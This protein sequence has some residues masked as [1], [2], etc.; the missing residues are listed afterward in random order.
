[1]PPRK[2]TNSSAPDAHACPSRRVMRSSSGSAGPL[3]F[4]LILM[5]LTSSSVQHFVKT[6]RLTGRGEG[7]NPGNVPPARTLLAQL[8]E[9]LGLTGK[10]EDCGEGD[11]GACTVAVGQIKDSTLRFRGIK[12]C[13]RCRKIFRATRAAAPAIGRFRTLHSTWPACRQSSSTQAIFYLLLKVELLSPVSH[14]PKAVFLYAFTNAGKYFCSAG[15]STAV[16]CQIDI[17]LVY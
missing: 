1:M 15:Q 6:I 10:K 11:C 13:L 12:S 16:G 4:N 3:C 8:R 17:P 7:V 9:D 5:N 14:A 2:A